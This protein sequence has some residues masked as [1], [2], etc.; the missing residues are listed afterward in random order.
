MR[1]KGKTQDF[2]D[3]SP[4]GA[5]LDC[6]LRSPG[7]SR[8]SKE[9]LERYSSL[10]PRDGQGLSQAHTAWEAWSWNLLLLPPAA[11]PVAL[12]VLTPSIE[13][14]HWGW[15]IIPYANGKNVAG[16]IYQTPT[17]TKCV[18]CVIFSN[19]TSQV[20]PIL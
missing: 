11:L 1:F 20:A 12:A 4:L 17:S 16:T 5:F 7:D 14:L 2:K 8:V 10:G 9:K 3:A 15:S 18:L 6:A 19:P 13:S